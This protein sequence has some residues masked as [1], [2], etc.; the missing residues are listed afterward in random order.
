MSVESDD[1]LLIF[2]DSDEFGVEA[3]YLARGADEVRVL[4]GI[5]DDEGSN[6]N[7]NRWSGTEFQAQMGASITSTGPTFLC[8]ASD[9]LKGGR[10]GETLT[11]KGQ[12]YRIEDKRPDGTGM[13]LLLLMAND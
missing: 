11:I 1:D 13:T 2:L 3:A 5:F 7:P 9:L 6:W 8:R 4:T 12:E 10:K